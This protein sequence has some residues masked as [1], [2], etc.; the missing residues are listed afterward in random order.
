[1]KSRLDITPRTASANGLYNSQTLA[2]FIQHYQETHEFTHWLQ[3]VIF[4]RQL[5]YPLSDARLRKAEQWI[6]SP[7]LRKYQQRIYGHKERQLKNLIDEATH[8]ASNPAVCRK[9]KRLVSHWR[10]QEYRQQRKIAQQI[11]EAKRVIVVGNSPNIRGEKQGGWIDQ[12]DIV[13]RFNHCFSEHT[14]STDSGSKLDL[15]VV[16]PDYRGPQFPGSTGTIIT[17]PNMLWWQ[18]NWHYFQTLRGPLIG[19]PMASWRTAVALLQAPPSAGFL[20]L[21][22]LRH[23]LQVE[24]ISTIGFGF[25]G[26]GE[27]HNAIKGHQAV[28]RHNWQREKEL[29]STWN[30]LNTRS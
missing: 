1:M 3:K 4:M 20:L 17:G 21:S 27:Y 26:G 12:H 15:W 28:S 23:Q 16:A 2:A 22:W 18:Q 10:S 11:K 8:H 24:S 9:D 25:S 19:L 6:K 29:L 5:G 7:F 13:I 14:Q 30:L